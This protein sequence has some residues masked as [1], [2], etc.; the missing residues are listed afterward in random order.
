[1]AEC[2]G[3]SDGEK[4]RDLAL[5]VKKSF[6]DSGWHVRVPAGHTDLVAWGVPAGPELV[7]SLMRELGLEPCQPR[8]WRVSL[9]EGDGQE[10][11]IP[12]LVNRDFD[13]CAPGEK[14]VGDIT[15]ISTW[16]G[17]LFLATVIDCHTKAVIGWATDDNYKTPLIEKAIEMAA[18]NYPLAENAIFPL[19]PR[20]QLHV[21]PV[22]RD[23]EAVRPPAV[24]RP[25][26]D[27]LRQCDGRVVLCCVERT[28]AF[29]APSIRLGA[30]A[31]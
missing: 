30:R 11:D 6:G 31:P 17:W 2:A 1:M 14:M 12:D 18:R 22:R 10:H 16:E 25:Y 29:T 8:P 5:Y 26:R 15:Y 3:I 20:Q 19:R 9:T 13:R 28:S 27:L 21:L 24:G 7:R 4:A 23:A